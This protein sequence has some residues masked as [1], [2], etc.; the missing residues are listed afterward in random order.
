[1]G[2]ESDPRVDFAPVVVQHGGVGTKLTMPWGTQYQLKN[3]VYSESLAA[4]DNPFLKPGADTDKVYMESSEAEYSE[5]MEIINR[6][7]YQE[8]RDIYG[9]RVKFNE[10]GEPYVEAVRRGDFAVLYHGTNNPNFGENYYV[11][12]PQESGYAE[13]GADSVL[14]I[15]TVP[16]YSLQYGEYLYE[17]LIPW[18]EY[19]TLDNA[20]VEY[21][22]EDGLQNE[23]WAATEHAVQRIILNEKNTIP[24]FTRIQ[25][26]DAMLER[27]ERL[28]RLIDLD[29][30]RVDWA[31]EIQRRESLKNTMSLETPKQPGPT[32]KRVTQKLTEQHP[33]FKSF[34]GKLLSTNIM[35]FIMEADLGQLSDVVLDSIIDGSFNI[36]K[37]AE[38]IRQGHKLN[39][40]TFNLLNKHIYKND[41]I[42]TQ[43]QLDKLTHIS[44]A[45]YY[46]M[47]EALQKTGNIELLNRQLSEEDFIL[48]TTELLKSPV[49]KNLFL[50]IKRSFERDGK[51]DINIGAL[52]LAFLR[53]FDGSI[54]QA[55]AA[56]KLIRNRA[57][58]GISSDSSQGRLLS[59][60]SDYLRNTLA[61]TGQSLDDMTFDSIKSTVVVIHKFKTRLAKTTGLTY[62]QAKKIM[63]DIQT[64]VDAFSDRQVEKY[65]IDNNL[66]GLLRDSIEHDPEVHGKA[67]QDFLKR[68]KIKDMPRS[69]IA[70][71]TAVFQKELSTLTRKEKATQILNQRME[72]LYE[73]HPRVSKRKAQ[74]YKNR[75]ITKLNRISEDAI[76]QY[77]V[78]QRL[79]EILDTLDLVSPDIQQTHRKCRVLPLYKRTYRGLLTRS[80]N[81]I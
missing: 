33:V 9:Q 5:A 77:L 23:I 55:G 36:R 18:N 28:Q 59:L 51:L 16:E 56:A 50:S 20:K 75:L 67:Y 21:F 60:D 54:E 30:P 78:Q 47:R 38:I 3:S 7:V 43:E 31:R 22:F 66:V 81:E 17:V 37:S 29:N 48:L 1:M 74:E 15:S 64:E 44:A 40:Y 34:K 73:R 70:E 71:A 63:Q 46:A 65:I 13:M 8:L 80:M 72:M 79:S 49:F 39:E 24:L 14:F 25:K 10:V 58:A 53:T 26:T 62:E 19:L 41:Y 4:K 27:Y 69:A 6:T 32:R 76:D 12:F 61:A 11:N 35:D 42:K 57:V 52:R 45:D 68:H 2:M